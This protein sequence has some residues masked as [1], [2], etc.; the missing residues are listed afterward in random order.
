MP[1]SSYIRE[2][3]SRRDSAGTSTMTTPAER[4][5]SIGVTSGMPASVRPFLR[6]PARS[7]IRFST[8]SVPISAWNSAVVPIAA[9]QASSRCPMDSN[10]RA[11]LGSGSASPPQPGATSEGQSFGMV[12]V[13]TTSTPHSLGPQNHLW[14][15][16]VKVSAP[17]AG[18]STDSPPKLWAPSTW[19][20]MPRSC[21]ASAIR[22]T[23][24]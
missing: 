8:R 21:A 17:I 10:F 15:L 12:S 18:T 24:R 13:R 3:T 1:C 7:Y 11:P 2:N 22:R 9:R 20:W 14:E 5:S 6:R 19:T 23:G 16:L 4:A